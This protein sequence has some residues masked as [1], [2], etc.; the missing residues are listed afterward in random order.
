MAEIMG[1]AIN[2]VFTFLAGLAIGILVGH[3]RF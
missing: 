1:L 2:M 3:G